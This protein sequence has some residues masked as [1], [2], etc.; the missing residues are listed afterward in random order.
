VDST[1]LSAQVE[2]IDLFDGTAALLRPIRPSDAAGL[3]RFH[4]QLSNASIRLRFFSLHTHL[5]DD[6]V[7]RFTNVDGTDRV[8]LVVANANELI[9]VGRY[10]RCAESDVAE[11]AFVV[12]D[13]FQH[14]GLGSLL[15]DRLAER[16]RAVGIRTLRAET[17]A[18]NS[19]MLGVFRDSGYPMRTKTSY[20]VVEVTLDIASTP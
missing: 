2:P 6:E 18:E 13:H 8:A 4:S 16:A 10:D 5:T 19:L 17:L 7:E 3:L 15:L 12:A 9:A 11:V 14:H 1:G 20:G